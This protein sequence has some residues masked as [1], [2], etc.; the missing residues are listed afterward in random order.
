M[1]FLCGFLSKWIVSDAR[2]APQAT[3]QQLAFVDL[4]RL[5]D[6]QPQGFGP[7]TCVPRNIC[8]EPTYKI[9][10]CI[11]LCCK[12]SV[13]LYFIDFFVIFLRYV[14]LT[15]FII[16][17]LSRTLMH[18]GLYLIWLVLFFR[19]FEGTVF[20]TLDNLPFCAFLKRN[21]RDTS[22]IIMIQ[23]F[24]NSYHS[25]ILNNHYQE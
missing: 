16:T 24:N 17:L 9:T 10:T 11:A 22:L 4:R 3:S 12:N 23:K 6:T 2:N 14:N 18:V 7:M 1:N 19:Y 20:T 25:K 15:Y 21:M 13:H 8:K 5:P